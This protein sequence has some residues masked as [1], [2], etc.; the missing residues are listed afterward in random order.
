[1]TFDSFQD[2]VS[3][4]RRNDSVKGFTAL[5]VDGKV[6][7]AVVVS[8]LK[9]ML[10]EYFLNDLAS[11]CF[12]DF[13]SGAC[14]LVKGYNYSLKSIDDLENIV[15]DISL[16]YEKLQVDI[17]IA[18]WGSEKLLEKIKEGLNGRV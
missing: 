10:L 4:H 2:L 15:Y 16:R 13:S 3:F 12:K 8:Q 6:I 7:D 14:D 9:K 5:A 11:F 17:C 1:M 18:V